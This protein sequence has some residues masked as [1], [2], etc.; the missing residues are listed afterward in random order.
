MSEVTPTRKIKY[1]KEVREMLVSVLPRPDEKCIKKFDR[2]VDY[3]FNAMGEEIANTIH[4]GLKCGISLEDQI[5][6]IK[7]KRIFRI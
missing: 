3:Y 6:R 5:E 7:A 2:T 4:Y 1:E